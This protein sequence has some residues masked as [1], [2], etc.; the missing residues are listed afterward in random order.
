M[1]RHGGGCLQSQH[2]LGILATL[3]LPI[4]LVDLCVCSIC[5]DVHVCTGSC[6]SSEFNIGQ[7]PLINLSPLGSLAEAG[8]HQL[9][10][11]TRHQLFGE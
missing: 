8:T 9:A 7:F 3:S 4:L 2:H 6:E 10:R 1:S 11:R 5:V